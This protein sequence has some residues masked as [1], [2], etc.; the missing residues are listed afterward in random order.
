M[1]ANSIGPKRGILREVFSFP[2]PVNEWSARTVAAMVVALTV[3]IILTDLHWLMYVLAY[4]FLARVITGPTL[5]PMGLLATKVI[6]PKL[7]RRSTLVAGPPKRFAQ[8]VG[9]SSQPPRLS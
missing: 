8:T 3:T 5:S 9:L 4:G 2:H 1:A 6:V 7:I